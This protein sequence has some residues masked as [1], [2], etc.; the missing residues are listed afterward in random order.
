MQVVKKWVSG[1]SLIQVRDLALQTLSSL[2]WV[3]IYFISLRSLFTV[4]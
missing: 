4:K 3:V 2:N 1:D